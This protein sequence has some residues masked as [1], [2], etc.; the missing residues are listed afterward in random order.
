MAVDVI[1]QWRVQA[2]GDNVQ[3]LAQQKVNRLMG[4]VRVAS[5]LTGKVKFWDRLSG[6]D[7]QQQTSRNGDTQ[8]VNIEESRRA[9]FKVNYVWSKP[10]DEEDQLEQIQNLT[11]ELAVAASYAVNRRKDQ[12]IIDAISGSAAFG[13]SG[14]SSIALPSAQ[15][16]TTASGNTLAKLITC[17]KKLN[18]K[19]YMISPADTV[20]IHSP[21]SLEDLMNLATF[22]SRDYN[23]AMSLMTGELKSYLGMSWV[24]STLLP[25]LSGTVRGTYLVQRNAIGF[26]EWVNV[27]ASINQRHDKN[28]LWQVLVKTMHGAVRVEDEM[29][30]ENQVTE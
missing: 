18:L 7:M 14:S 28:D 16:E 17:I 24:M 30:V 26:G 9:C 2:Y 6:A 11:S 1:E 13:E 23:A 4:W 3:H 12:T 19:D 27:K 10:V 29:V 21:D 20:Y 8:W 25:I 22:T 15:K 5:G